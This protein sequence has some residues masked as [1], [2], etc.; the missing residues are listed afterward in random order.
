MRR[1]IKIAE[2]ISSYNRRSY[3]RENEAAFSFII[4]QKSTKF[5]EQH[6]T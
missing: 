5:S 1:E 4:R 2:V 3:S 6:C